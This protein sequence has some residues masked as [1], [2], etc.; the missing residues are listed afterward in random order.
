MLVITCRAVISSICARRDRWLVDQVP[1]RDTR[2]LSLIGWARSLE[3][4]TWQ[5]VFNWPGSLGTRTDRPKLIEGYSKPRKLQ[6]TEITPKHRHTFQSTL[7]PFDWPLFHCST[8]SPFYLPLFHLPLFQL[9]PFHLPL[10]HPSTL[11]PFHSSTF[12]PSCHDTVSR[13]VLYCSWVVT[14]YLYILSNFVVY[15]TPHLIGQFECEVSA[16]RRVIGQ[17]PLCGGGAFFPVRVP[18]CRESTSQCLVGVRTV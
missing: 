18:A 4:P 12:H 11:P 5:Y 2:L 6:Y 8:F 1:R 7:P 14:G 10:F 17:T 3:G 13:L 9:S 15:R 16:W